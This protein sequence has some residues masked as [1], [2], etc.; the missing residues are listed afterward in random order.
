MEIENKIMK[1]KPQKFR[2]A[3]KFK[4]FKNIKLHN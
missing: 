2:K 3:Q 4:L 1:K